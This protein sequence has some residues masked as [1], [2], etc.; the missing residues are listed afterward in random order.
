MTKIT[1]MK[2]KLTKV[3]TTATCCACEQAVCPPTHL[4]NHPPTFT[5]TRPP[6]PALS[7]VATC[8]GKGF[9]PFSLVFV[10]FF[11]RRRLVKPST[12]SVS[13]TAGG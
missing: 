4:P 11:T 9:S 3:M 5:P 1:T 12:V 13:E 8:G 6:P 2:T 7:I 10:T